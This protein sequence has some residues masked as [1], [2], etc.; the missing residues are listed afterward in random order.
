MC[1]EIVKLGATRVRKVTLGPGKYRGEDS[2][3]IVHEPVTVDCHERFHW[4]YESIQEGNGSHQEPFWKHVR[5]DFSSVQVEAK[6]PEP[7]AP[8]ELRPPWWR[9]LFGH[10][11]PP[12]RVV[13]R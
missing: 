1:V 13:Q 8:V 11:I 9:R 6:D 12:A 7:V 4:F 5:Y 2:W 10:K 3:C